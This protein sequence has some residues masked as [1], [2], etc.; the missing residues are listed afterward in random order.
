MSRKRMAGCRRL[1]VLMALILARSVAAETVWPEPPEHPRIRFVRSITP[2]EAGGKPSFLSKLWGLISGEKKQY[3]MTQPY[4]VCLGPGGRLFV[5]DTFGRCLHV[6]DLPKNAYSNMRIDGD[7]LIGVAAGSDRLY[8]TD[9][10]RRRLVCLNPKGRELWTIGAEAGFRRPTGLAVVGDQL[11][12]VDTLANKI[13]SVTRDGKIVGQF[14]AHGKGP[15]EFNFPTNIA[16]GPGGRLYVCD[17]MNFRVQ[18]FDAQN[19]YISSFGKLGDSSGDFNRP[20]GI[21]V[22]SDGNIYV[23]EGLH[24]V[25]QIFDESGRL[26]LFFGGSGSGEGDLWL[27][28][29]I[30]I[31]D[32]RICVADSANRRIQVY[33]Y[34]KE[35]R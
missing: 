16:T 13:V 6:Y 18:I 24:D 1:P 9:S 30:A 3:V 31:Q 28:T 12:V 27:P 14:G 20:K 4:G 23:V 11:R 15:G 34:L 17:S 35:S 25:V 10:A 21:A 5:A 7:S 32:D 19:R 33:E 2:A 26:L 22:D 8:V 29:G